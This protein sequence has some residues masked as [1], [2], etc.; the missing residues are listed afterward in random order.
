MIKTSLQLCS[1]IV[2][3]SRILMKKLYI[4]LLLCVAVSTAQA[5]R[6]TRNY[7]AL[8]LSRVLKDLNAATGRYEISF[9][10]NELEDFTV[11]CSFERVSLEDA[12]TKI[13]GFYPIRVVKDG[14]K[15]FVECTHKTECHLKG[16]LIDENRQPLAYANITLLNPV[17]SAFI[18]GGV[19]NENGDFV[20]PTE[21][22][23]VMVRCS[24]V[25]YKTIFRI[26]DVGDI[27]TLQMQPAQYTIQGVTVKGSHIMN[28]VDK[29]VHTFSAEQ[30]SIARNVRDLLEYVEDL[31]IDPISNKI[32]RMDGG[33]VKI[34][35]NGISASDIDLKG[36]PANKILK[37]EYYNIPPA[38]YA[39]AS[40]VINVI[41]KKMDNGVN[42]GIEAS[43][44]FNTGFS[45]DAAYFNL[46]SGNHQLSL[47]YSFN[48]R[49]YT[50]RY[51][52]NTYD[53]LL[54]DEQIH[55]ASHSHDKFGY[56]WNDP[57]IRYTYNKPDDI[58][59]Q[60]VATPH[61]DHYHS[62]G[63]DDI[64]I[65]SSSNNSAFPTNETQAKGTDSTQETTFGPSLN[66]YLQ[67]KMSGGQQLDI[68]LVGTYYHSKSLNEKE[69]NNLSNGEILLADV[70]NQKN[71][72]H[73]FI[74]ELAY[75]KKWTVNSLSLG[76]RG[77]FGRSKATISNVLSNYQ[78]YGY[79]SA[80]YQHYMYAEY[81][82]AWNKLTYRIGAGMTQ[83]TQ[84]NSDA[85]DSHWLFT[86]KLI[87]STN[88]SKTMSL[89]W[90]TSSQ[91]T[92]PAIS[93]LSNNASMVIPGVMTVG[94]PWLKSYNSYQTLLI[95]K[96]NLGWL[97][98]QLSLCYT[99]IDSPIS[100]YYTEQVLNGQKYIVGMNENANNASQVGGSYLLSVKPFNNET[101]TLTL[102]GHIYRQTVSSPII[103]T[104]HHTWAPFYFNINYRKGCWGASYEGSIV[105]KMMNGPELDAGEN[106]S[107]L[108]VFWQ[109]RGWRIYACDYW[110]FTRA[111]YSGYSLPTSIL[112]SSW[113]TKI[114]DNRSM[115]VLGFSYDFSSG[116]NLQLQRK[117]QN[118]DTDTGVF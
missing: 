87:L 29:S 10:Y 8:S 57:V 91:P 61:F 97:R 51:Q 70:V 83:V 49:D 66:V 14:E 50:Q 37:V 43:T 11:T 95:N 73:S 42:A 75:T 60:V 82:G 18:G 112:Q 99:Y 5:Q 67:K 74:G 101:L 77:S 22:R 69:K 31:K 36:I 44:A 63:H 86:P 24:F 65:F 92:I 7:K 34:L 72:K 12:L 62:D 33:D 4:L 105:S 102:Q 104:Y 15:L 108:T 84:D 55:Y 98:T 28:Y 26:C 96:W 23:R 2:K 56:T 117:L 115:F 93:E 54:N 9:V 21:S 76:Y 6:I 3:E 59:I 16:R 32:K 17:D 116:K 118:K 68:D 64:N 90:Y 81:A 58:A 41:T 107:H 110:L 45:N 103:G 19:S 88:L 111:R 40:T 46:T 114:N 35:L 27:G 47:S 20:I 100:K 38:R 30:I 89:Q 94:N 48:L 39:N 53:Y 80:S 25:G 85:H 106:E 13:I 79:T 1:L 109:K 71:D 52:E 78:D 113:K